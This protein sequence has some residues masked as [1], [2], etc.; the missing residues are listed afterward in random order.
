MVCGYHAG[1][2]QTKNDEVVFSFFFFFVT[3]ILNV[4]GIQVIA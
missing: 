2:V 4:M 3:G 1:I